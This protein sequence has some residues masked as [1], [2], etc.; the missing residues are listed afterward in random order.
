[1][2][3]GSIVDYNRGSIV[4][5]NLHKKKETE[6]TAT[7]INEAQREADKEKFTKDAL[8]IKTRIEKSRNLSNN[9]TSKGEYS[10]ENHIHHPIKRGNSL[11]RL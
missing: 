7:T 2:V 5:Y 6:S 9:E 11:P 10:E 8:I 4:D 3:R 1:V